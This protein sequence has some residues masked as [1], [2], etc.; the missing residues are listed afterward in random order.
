MTVASAIC[1]NTGR[2]D[3]SA[4]LLAAASSLGDD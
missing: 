3:K 1:P 4:R 2:D